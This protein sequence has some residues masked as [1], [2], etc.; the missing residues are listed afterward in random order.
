MSARWRPIAAVVASLVTGTACFGCSTATA[1]YQRTIIDGQDVLAATKS[2]VPVR[3]V[4]VYFHG[5]DRDESIL[6]LDEPHRRLTEDLVEAGFPVVASSAG[7]NAYGSLKSQ[8]NYAA[9]AYD[10][11]K[12]FG[13]DKVFFIAESMGTLA[14]VRLMASDKNLPV[15]GLAGINPLLNLDALQSKYRSAV[16]YANPGQSIEELSPF[17]LPAG[18]MKAENLRFY[19]TPDD[20]LVSTADNAAAFQTKFGGAANISLVTCEGEHLDPSCIQGKDIVAW[21]NSLMSR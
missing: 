18:S 10:A 9:L 3:G 12:H 14:A 16:E 8:E 4:V 19:V 7:G 6:T 2:G 11:V 13:V 17:D 1:Q 21:F 15:V 5:L 20:Q